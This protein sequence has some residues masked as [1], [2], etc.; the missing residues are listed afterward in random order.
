MTS[1]QV[2]TDILAAG[3][4]SLELLC[5]VTYGEKRAEPRFGCHGF[6]WRADGRSATAAN[7]G[8]CRR[9]SGPCAPQTRPVTDLADRYLHVDC[10][11]SSLAAADVL[12]PGEGNARTPWMVGLP[13]TALWPVGMAPR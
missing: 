6:H 7:L 4:L 10:H 9:S 12:P 11:I 5:A 3:L 1:T 2:L 8:G 13:E